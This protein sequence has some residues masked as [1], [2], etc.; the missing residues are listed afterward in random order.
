MRRFLP[1]LVL[2]GL[3]ALPV[4]ADARRSPAGDGTLSVRRGKGVVQLAVRGTL[5][6]RVKKGTV[7]VV[8]TDPLD[9]EIPLVR[10]GRE[11]NRPFP[12]NG[13]T[14]V[15]R[16]I[17]IRAVDGFY[18]IKIKGVGIHLSAVGRGSVTIDGDDRFRDTGVF[19]LN[20]GGYRQIPYRK[21][22]F[23]LTLP[24]GG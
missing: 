5:I 2:S 18:R 4:V 7:T 17:R 24:Y 16:Q 22:T 1:V 9:D 10:G 19:S 11:V 3:L 20:G 6:A 23:Q 21:I 8:D 13:T 14:Y 15:G 12:A